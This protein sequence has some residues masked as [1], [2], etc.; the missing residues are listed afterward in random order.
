[1]E[2]SYPAHP[3]LSTPD[4][5]AHQPHDA[6]PPDWITAAATPPPSSRAR[7]ADG[8]TGEKR[9]IFLEELADT[10]L[11]NHAAAAAGMSHQSAYALR[12]RA[13]G[14]DFRIGWDAASR[15]ARQKLADEAYAR[16]TNGTRT[17]IR[18]KDRDVHEI[19]YRLN[20]RLLMQVLARLDRIEAENDH[21]SGVVMQEFDEFLDCMERDADR[22]RAETLERDS[23]TASD[24]VRFFEARRPQSDRESHAAPAHGVPVYPITSGEPLKPVDATAPEELLERLMRYRLYASADPASI[25]IDD[26][27]PADIANWTDEQIERA[28]WSGLLD[29]LPPDIWP[30]YADEEE[31]DGHEEGDDEWEEGEA[32]EESQFSAPS[33]AAT[34][35]TSPKDEGVTPMA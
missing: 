5:A 8:W 26:L 28:D 35:A 1:M 33:N 18:D 19:E 34:S 7:R 13:D 20:D 6:V 30:D 12:R 21:A 22:P 31:I 14:A 23:S 27:D 4:S 32:E 10:G 24:V 15:I 11:V 9:R 17:Y 25:P 16:A 3:A 29:R 2:Q